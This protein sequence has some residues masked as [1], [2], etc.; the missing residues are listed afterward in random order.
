MVNNRNGFTYA[1][2]ITVLC[3]ALILFVVVSNP[4]TVFST[5]TCICLGIGLC[6]TSFYVI[7]IKEHIL[8]DKAKKY[9]EEYREKL[10]PGSTATMN[11]SLTNKKKA[12]GKQWSD[13]LKE[14]QFYIFGFVYMFARLALNT[15][16]TMMPLYLAA[17]T[18]FD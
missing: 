2:N 9:E 8:S 14:G 17:V 6:T 10:D 13:W 3:T 12:G 11:S 16:A 18:G 7:R 15:T 4:T 1:A 5:L